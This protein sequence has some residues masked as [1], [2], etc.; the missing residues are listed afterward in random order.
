[1]ANR[2]EGIAYNVIPVTDISKAVEWY[3]KHLSFEVQHQ[4][5]DY[6]GLFFNNRP[7]LN[8]KK[9]DHPSR[10]VFECNGKTHWVITLYTK[11]I[12][13]LHTVLTEEGVRVGQ[14]YDEGQW[15]KFFTMHDPDGN[16]FDVW[17]NHDCV[18][19]F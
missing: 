14:V 1:M 16:M 3:S 12:Y 2:V 17:E 8:L 7:V 19:S 15:G 10:A 18:I 9:T 5:D 6:A 11:D 4:R 13:S